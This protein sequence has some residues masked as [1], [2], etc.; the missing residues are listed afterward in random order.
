MKTYVEY[1][2]EIVKNETEGMDAIYK[3]YII[4]IVGV[5]GFN[6]LHGARLLEGCGS[7]NLRELYILVDRKNVSIDEN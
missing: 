4:Q 2:Y 5:H 3:D 1:L 7:V 6:A